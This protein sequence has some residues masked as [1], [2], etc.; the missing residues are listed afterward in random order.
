[1]STWSKRKKRRRGR[2]N[3]DVDMKISGNDNR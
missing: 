3:I 2:R 1:M